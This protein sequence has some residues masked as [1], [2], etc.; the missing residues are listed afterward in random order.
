MPKVLFLVQVDW[1]P[2]HVTVLID[3]LRTVVQHQFQE[4]RR[5]IGGITAY[6]VVLHNPNNKRC[7]VIAPTA[8]C[9][10]VYTV[11]FKLSGDCLLGLGD[12]QLSPAFAGRHLT[13]QM[14][15]NAMSDESKHKAFEK[16][17]KDTGKSCTRSDYIY[18]HLTL[19]QH[20]QFVL[21]CYK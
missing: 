14:R 4:L 12:F 18:R 5:A 6:V 19:C 13:S 17:M 9:H 7:C 8:S 16:L 21:I 2:S 10:T 3:H 20:S 15:W 11:M 1:K